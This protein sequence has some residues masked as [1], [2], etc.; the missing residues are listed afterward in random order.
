MTEQTLELSWHKRAG[1]PACL[2]DAATTNP[3]VEA[4]WHDRLVRQAAY[5]RWQKRQPCAGKELEDWL[6][7]ER[8]VDDSLS[9]PA[10]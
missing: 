10:G 7:A 4:A 1:R 5:F 6:A 3:A 2:P 9:H 8:E